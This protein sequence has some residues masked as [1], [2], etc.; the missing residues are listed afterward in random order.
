MEA[1][2][3]AWMGFDAATNTNRRI[4]LNIVAILDISMKYGLHS[5]TGFELMLDLFK[6]VLARSNES[7]ERITS[8]RVVAP[9]KQSQKEA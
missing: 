9:K 4:L 7:K 1:G 3:F 2:G 5:T 6:T 8:T